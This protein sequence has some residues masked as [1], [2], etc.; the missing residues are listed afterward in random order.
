MP[1]SSKS[2]RVALNPRNPEANSWYD[3]TTK[4]NLFLSRPESGDLENF[5]L[6]ELEPVARGIR[7]GLLVI[8]KGD[9]P[10]G[11]QL[12]GIKTFGA[13]RYRWTAEDSAK[14]EQMQA[15]AR[16]AVANHERVTGA[17]T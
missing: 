4:T 16:S 11:L 6:K 2:F 1:P 13:P 5:S 7:A 3:P 9:V 12:E 17:K 14:Q 8:S 15:Q 10:A